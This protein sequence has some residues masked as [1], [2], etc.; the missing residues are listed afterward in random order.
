MKYRLTLFCAFGFALIGLATAQTSQ[1]HAPSAKSTS[2]PLQSA[3]KPLTPKSAK[4]TSDPLQS[5]TKPLT[6]KSAMPPS[7]HKSSAAVLPPSANVRKTN[8]ELSRVEREKIKIGHSA[9]ASKDSPK[10][11]PA[12]KSNEGNPAINYKYQKPVGGLKATTPDANAKSSSTPR[13]TKKK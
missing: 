4:S 2:D 13:V 12:P 5:A 11:A 1:V 7:S 10:V 9:S 3:T 6:P 8:A